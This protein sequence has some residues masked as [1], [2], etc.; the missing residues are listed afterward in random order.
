[1]P[2]LRIIHTA[3]WHLGHQLHGQ[4]R[5]YEH[6]HF[7][8]W[9]LKT[10]KAE[11]ADV[12]LVAG[13]IFDTSNPSATAQAQFY[14]FLS[15]ARIQFP[16]LDII[17][18]GGNHD[19]AARLDAPHPILDAFNI[20]IVGGF[21]IKNNEPDYSRLFIPLHN[22]QDEIQGWCIAMPFLRPTDLPLQDDKAVDRLIAGVK[23]RY[24]EAIDYAQNYVKEDQFLLATGHCYMANSS[25]SELSERR[26][27]GGNQHALPV[28]IFSDKLDYVA[29]GHMHLA[30][31]VAKQKHIRYSGS[32]I[33]LSLT[34]ERYK[35]QILCI[36]IDNKQQ[37]EIKSLHIPRTVEIIRLPKKALPLDK[38]LT[39][40]TELELEDL[41]EEQQP[42]LELNIKLDQPQPD[43]R[44][45]LEKA[46]QGKAVRLI[47]ITTSY[48]GNKES[49][50]DEVKEELEDINP[51]DVF[52][53]RWKQ[54]HEGDIPD[55]YL[56]AFRELV[57]TAI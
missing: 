40:I 19:S 46:L 9:L 24:Q 14:G 35:H 32:P 53:R 50:A 44:Q 41:E 28:D 20:H 39:L 54:D 7:L 4:S 2:K 31:Q 47:K 43:L 48:T 52:L 8:D 15:Q 36:E 25:I 18:I 30:Q 1:M 17:F 26:I 51:E 13:D 27:L 6:Q 37:L 29:L 56:N 22:E 23:Q 5:E 49:L 10:L 57:D 55:H 3:D 45:K 16:N 21:P 34:E 42:W 12:L 33:P 38:V 11:Q